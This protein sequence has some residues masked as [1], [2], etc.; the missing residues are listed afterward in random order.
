[1]KKALKI[2]ILENSQNI[3]FQKTV[4]I[5][6]FIKTAKNLNFQKPVK[7]LH[8]KSIKI[9]NFGKQSKLHILENR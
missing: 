4:K 6:N 9:S 3:T 7:I 2:Q 5:S 8:E 1:M